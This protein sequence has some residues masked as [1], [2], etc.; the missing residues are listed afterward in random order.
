MPLELGLDL[1]CK[2]Y[3]LDYQQEK[4]LLVLDVE[5]YRYQKF[6]SD[7]AGQDT[8]GHGGDERQVVQVLREWLRRELD[9]RI[10]IIPSGDRIYSRYQT[11]Q[12]DLPAICA[13]L[14]WN[15]AQ[16]GFIDFSYAVATWVSV[17]PL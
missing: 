6:I 9:P 11:F 15:P 17:N 4:V 3:G 10:V 12:Q 8:Y 14:Q 16:L 2:Q 1:G 13:R 7:I 5:Q